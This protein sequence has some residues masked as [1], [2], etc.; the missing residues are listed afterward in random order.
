MRWAGHRVREGHCS[1]PAASQCIHASDH[2]R[3]TDVGCIRSN[4]IE[5]ERLRAILHND[6]TST[7]AEKYASLPDRNLPPN[8]Y[9]YVDR[10][11]TTFM[12][13]ENSEIKASSAAPISVKRKLWMFAVMKV[14]LKILTWINRVYWHNCNSALIGICHQSFWIH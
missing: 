10:M 1:Q 6:K 9:K 14:I 7:S 4:K 12:E 5:Q 11:K 2:V 13:E 3:L 8:V